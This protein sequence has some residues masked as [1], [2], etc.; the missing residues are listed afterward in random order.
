MEVKCELCGLSFGQVTWIHLKYSH[1]TTLEE[2]GRRFPYSPTR[3]VDDTTRE[4]IS[5]GM[6]LYQRSLTPR[7]VEDLARKSFLS[8]EAMKK[9]SENSYLKTK[10]SE[11][12]RRDAVR[13]I[14]SLTPGERRRRLENS[15]LSKDA[16]RKREAQWTTERRVRQSSA[17]KAFRGSQTKEE[18]QARDRK[19]GES[20]RRQIGSLTLEQQEERLRNSFLSD[21][22]IENKIEALH[23][24]PTMPERF[25]GN[26]LKENFP[27]KFV[28]SGDNSQ[29]E[30]LRSIGYDGL[31]IPDFVSVTEEKE[32]VSVMGG[33]GFAHF[34]G[35]EKVEIEYYAK[36][37]FKCVVVW[38]W[39]CYIPGELDKIFEPRK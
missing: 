33:L 29:R 18:K 7:E 13:Y 5:K 11:E 17:I 21:E 34:L 15:L 31:R 4:L 1:G 38:E 23:Q 12:R 9:S 22:A 6:R 36:Y 10:S 28:Y 27:G 3:I 16:V 14:A 37:G 35:D 19:A 8:P 24:R 20:I 32:V 2:Y 30:Y 26:Y 39:D 25:M